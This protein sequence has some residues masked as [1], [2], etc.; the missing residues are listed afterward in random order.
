MRISI[1]LLLAVFVDI[2]LGQ[3]TGSISGRVYDIETNAPLIGAN[4][5]I[6]GTGRGA[7]T[8]T[9][10]RFRVEGLPVGTYRLQFGYIGYEPLIATDIVVSSARPEFLNIGLRQSYLEVGD[11]TIQPAYFSDK[12]ESAV[13]TTRLSR[14][15]VRRFPGGFEDVV[16]T[17][18]TLPG[19]SVVNEGGR[20]DLLVRGGGPSENLYLINGIEVPNINHFGNQ[21]GTSGALSFVNLDFVD[22]VEFSA[23]GISARYGDKM[24][25]LLAIDFRSGRKDR[26]GGKATISASQYGLNLEGPLSGNGDF[27]FSARQSYLD[28]IFKAAGQPFVPVYTDFNFFLDYELSA[29]DK[30]EVLG[31]LALDRVDRDQ[32]TQENREKNVDLLD[33]SQNQFVSGLRYRRLLR[34]AYIDASIQFNLNQ[35]RFR[36]VDSSQREFFRS[37]A[38]ET[39][40]TGKVHAFFSIG[41]DSGLSFGLTSRQLFDTNKVEFADSIYDRSGRQNTASGLGLPQYTDAR[42]DARQH[43]VYLEWEQGFG[44]KAEIVLGMRGD[45]YNYLKKP[46]YPSWRFSALFR[47][48]ER[49]RLKASFGRYYQS[50]STVWITNLFNRDLVA[51]RN[52]MQILGFSW[53]LRNDTNLTFEGY[54][55]NY[56]DLPTGIL[57]GVTDY[58]VL[59]NTG[60]GYGGSEEDFQSFGYFDLVSQGK[61]RAYGLEFSVQKKYSDT[62]FYGQ[63]SLSFGRSEYTAF[64]GKTYPGQFDQRVVLNMTGGYKLS[65]KW[66]ISGKFRV[67]SGAPFTP[68]YRPSENNGQIQNLP[69]EYLSDRLK[70]GH[71]L[72]LRLDRRFNFDRWSMVLFLDV[73]NIYNKRLQTKPRYEA[74]EDKIENTNAIGVLPSVGISA[75]W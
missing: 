28:L 67:F 10:G 22:Q 11:V 27:L 7:A 29:S 45:Y 41:R 3:S 73:Q 14:E 8:D 38:E 39:E 43:A 53:L 64:N 36:Q 1:I 5:Q 12:L 9:L 46:F 6:L 21:G 15:E 42:I 30:I 20:N 58:I 13:N 23:G 59:T 24:S 62:P 70:V 2:L 17:V 65:E 75:E 40:L 63:V 72:D 48:S 69:E 71:H 57:L 55:K 60:V 19:V 66:E 52:D 47:A 25:S 68:V 37:D 56:R 51:L 4:V 61:G 31:L 32:S 74:W 18:A 33:N 44:Q 26:I 16:R 50:P 54:S 34:N 35:F 49:L